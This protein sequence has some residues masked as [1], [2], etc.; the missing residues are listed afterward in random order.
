V[1]PLNDVSEA[2][3]LENNKYQRRAEWHLGV[4]KRASGEECKAMLAEHSAKG[5]LQSGA[6]LKRAVDIWSTQAGLA[7]DAVLAE[8]GAAI[9]KRGREWDKAMAAVL[10]AIDKHAATADAD[11]SPTFR[12]ASPRGGESG[13][14][15]VAVR[16]LLDTADGSLRDR[17][18]AYREGWTAPRP[19][20]WNERHPIAFAAAMAL[21]GAGLAIAGRAL[22]H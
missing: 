17:V 11:L 15:M 6:T 10:E 14:A 5:M 2:H 8:F 3:D 20:K 7:V 4:A 19:K 16:K 13:S 21:A 22:I 1:L 9:E 18:A 12:V